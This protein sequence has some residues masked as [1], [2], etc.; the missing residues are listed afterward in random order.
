[1]YLVFWGIEKEIMKKKIR[2]DEAKYFRGKQID[3]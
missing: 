1:M 3:P 2:L